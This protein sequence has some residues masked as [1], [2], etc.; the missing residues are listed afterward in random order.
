MYTLMQYLYLAQLK[1]IKAYSK[2]TRFEH[3]TNI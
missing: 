2:H 1:L 3:Y